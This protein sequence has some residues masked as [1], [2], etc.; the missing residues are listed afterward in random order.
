[1][2]IAKII[3]GI[4]IFWTILSTMTIRHAVRGCDYDEGTAFWFVLWWFSITALIA[5]TIYV[6]AS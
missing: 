3:I 5:S 6:W 4:S 1:M 2:L